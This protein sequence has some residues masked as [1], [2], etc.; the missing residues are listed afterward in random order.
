MGAS[1]TASGMK[2]YKPRREPGSPDDVIYP[3]TRAKMQE[4]KSAAADVKE[5]AKN[6]ADYNKSLTTEN[7]AKGGLTASSRADGCCTKGKTRGKM[8]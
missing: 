5:A 4:A 7:K 1:S 2:N 3:E 8:V 6:E